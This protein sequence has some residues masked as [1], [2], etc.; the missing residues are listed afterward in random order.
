LNRLDIFKHVDV[1]L[2]KSCDPFAHP[3]AIDV[4]LSVEEK[5]RF[6]IKTGTPIGNDA[7]SAVC[8]YLNTGIKKIYLYYTIY[9]I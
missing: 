1:L 4:I 7:G 5:S 3:E 8:Y 6:W 9:L 2:D